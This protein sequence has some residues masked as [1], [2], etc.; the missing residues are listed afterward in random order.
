[1]SITSG[2]LNIAVAV[3]CGFAAAGAVVALAPAFFCG[4]VLAAWSALGLFSSS[5]AWALQSEFPAPLL[6]FC[7]AVLSAGSYPQ[8][9]TATELPWQ[10]EDA[11]MSDIAVNQV[12]LRNVL[13]ISAS[14]PDLSQVSLPSHCNYSSQKKPVLIVWSE[15]LRGL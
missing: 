5:V 8:S 11:A 15:K 14:C 1:M 13:V 3:V 7:L 6:L 2:W 9:A 10:S 4:A 12:L